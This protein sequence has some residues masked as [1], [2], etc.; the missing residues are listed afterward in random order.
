VRIITALAFCA[1][2]CGIALAARLVHHRRDS[3]VARLLTGSTFL[4]GLVLV[5]VA[6]AQWDV[7]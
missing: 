4:F 7:N 1:V 2:T 6:L 5:G 3:R